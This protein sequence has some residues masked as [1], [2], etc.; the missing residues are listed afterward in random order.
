MYY[1][2]TKRHAIP[3]VAR[4]D[5]IYKCYQAA[6]NRG[7][8]GLLRLQNGGWC[9]SSSTADYGRPFVSKIWH[10]IPAVLSHVYL[11]SFLL[12]DIRAFFCH[13][14]LRPFLLCGVFIPKYMTIF[15]QTGIYM[16]T[17]K[18]IYMHYKQACVYGVTESRGIRGT[19]LYRQQ[20][21]LLRD[22]VRYFTNAD[23]KNDRFS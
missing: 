13:V 10:D 4:E 23:R 20:K 14:Y 2:E 11:Q 7:F 22:C 15:L 9:A 5:L 3:T 16:R 1:V 12:H 6:K 18:P 19:E 21:T 8:H 17:K